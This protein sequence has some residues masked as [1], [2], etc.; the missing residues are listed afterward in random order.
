MKIAALISSLVSLTL[1]ALFALEYSQFE[2]GNSRVLIPL[3]LEPKHHGIVR[4]KRDTKPTTANHEPKRTRN[5]DFCSLAQDAFASRSP[6]QWWTTHFD[7][8]LDGS[9][10]PQDPDGLY[11]NW[12]LNLLASLSPEMLQQGVRSRPSG[13]AMKHVVEVLRNR[14]VDPDNSPPLKIAVVGGSVTRG[15]GSHHPRLPGS[16]RCD[17]TLCAWPSRL[18]RLI[19]SLAGM[20]LVKVSN[21]AVSAT[22]LRFGTPLVK[23]WFYPEELLPDG[24]DIII[25]SYSTNEQPQQDTTKSLKFANRARQ[26]V[27]EFITTSREARPCQPPLIM[28]VDDYL[29]NFQDY[30]LGE[31][32]YNKVVTEVSE[33]YGEAMHV[34]YADVVRRHIYAD[35]SETTFTSEWPL[36]PKSGKAEVQVHFGMGGHVAIAW[37]VL[38]G[39]VDVAMNY[40]ENQAFEQQM[41]VGGHEGV[42]PN[43]VVDKVN[44]V[45]PPKLN[46]ELTLRSVSRKW[47]DNADRALASHSACNST[48]SKSPCTFAFLAGL[49]GWNA[50]ELGDFLQPYI[51]KSKGWEPKVEY[52]RGKKIEKPGL[53]ATKA[54]ASMTMQLNDIDK[55]VR[56][57]NIQRIKSY[58]DKWR[59]SKAR[60]TIRVENPGKAA[61]TTYFDVDGYH[62]IKTR[63]GLWILSSQCLSAH[64]SWVLIIY[65]FLFQ[66]AVYPILL[67]ST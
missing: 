6:S 60:F 61:F 34:S 3:S 41:K 20:E 48:E 54:K 35:T 55:V 30:I 64:S 45:P 18:E 57:I 38:F 16:E 47:Q 1:L 46:Q 21:L 10:H 58:G 42:F 59:G 32:T 2:P 5:D 39:M 23:Y 25:N 49:Q 4:I 27:Q 24:P 11:R 28:F 26:R 65:S 43:A 14:I 36:D 67:S 29:G 40:C 33:W 56:V 22:T 17:S 63:Y 44:S 37:S 7:D 9:P 50:E 12:T 53:V 52:G 66:L 15:Q 31:M 8:I 19:N 13:H 62:K 51:V